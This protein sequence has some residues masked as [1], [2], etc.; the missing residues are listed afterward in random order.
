[1]PARLK[2]GYDGP[3]PSGN[4]VAVMDLVRLSELTGNAEFRAQAEKTLSCFGEAIEKQP[5]AHANFLMGMDMLVNGVSEVV[6]ASPSA[7]GLKG[8]EEVVWGTYF[9][10]KAV[11]P[12]TS[13]TF[14]RLAKSSALLEGRKPGA[15]PRA[16]LC[17]GFACKLPADSPEVLARQLAGR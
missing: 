6:L 2:E 12:A 16:Y 1:V 14:E 11:V 7:E 9:P 8:F 5:T 17:V 15:R 3:T 4:S 10:N 13:K